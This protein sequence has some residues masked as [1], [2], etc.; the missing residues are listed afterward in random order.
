[1][2]KRIE[3]VNELIKNE[4]SVYIHREFGEQ[5][6]MIVVNSVETERDLK[7]ASIYVSGFDE[8]KS[9]QIISKLQSKAH[10]F[11]QALAKRLL[12]KNIPKLQF[13]FDIHQRDI[14][15]I[16]ELLSKIENEKK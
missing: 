1:M 11:Q 8:K 4:L 10:F 13:V 9:D 3:K 5:L 15:R 16:Q 12:L 14:D 6:G 7:S 2:S